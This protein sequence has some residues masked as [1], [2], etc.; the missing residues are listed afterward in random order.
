MQQQTQNNLASQPLPLIDVPMSVFGVNS[1][2]TV[3]GLSQPHEHAP[4]VN[5]IY[6]WTTDNLV[7]MRAFFMSGDIGMYVTGHMGCGKSSV[8][9]QWHARLGL[10]L[11]TLSC[12][13]DTDTTDLFG[14]NVCRQGVW[15]FEPGPVLLAAIN[16]WSVLLDE[17]NLVKPGIFSKINNLVEGKTE[18]IQDLGI[19]I[20]PRQGF[21]VF[22]TANIDN[23]EGVY[24]GRIKQ[25]GATDERFWFVPIDYPKKEE[26]KPILLHILS[27]ACPPAI[28][29]LL[30]DVMIDV[31][32]KVRSLFVAQSDDASA[33]EVTM[34]TRTLV[35]WAQ[36]AVLFQGS[37]KRGIEP[38]HLALEYCLTN[39]P[40]SQAT[41]KTIH[42]LLEDKLGKPRDLPVPG[43]VA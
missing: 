38:M 18:Y 40:I 24:K 37:D 4:S 7:A 13:N 39:R 17:A 35:K 29:D 23:G 36:K 1:P 16:G 6:M 22:C 8:V 43:G 20:T 19:S 14:R 34:S 26:E 30:A 12:A 5:P 33:I 32:H 3:K 2:A 10:P 28:A 21:R 41:R 25:D 42:K 9:Q 27:G 15:V 11:I 31:A